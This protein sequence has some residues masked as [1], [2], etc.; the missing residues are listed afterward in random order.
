[1]QHGVYSSTDRKTDQAVR[2]ALEPFF[3]PI[4][5]LAT[6][7]E[8]GYPW[9][10]VNRDDVPK[11]YNHIQ[12]HLL[13]WINSAESNFHGVKAPVND[14][15]VLERFADK[16]Y[17]SALANPGEITA[18]SGGG[19]F[20]VAVTE[21]MKELMGSLINEEKRKDPLGVL[22]PKREMTKR[23]S[24]MEQILDLELSP[25]DRMMMRSK[26]T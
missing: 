5:Q 21:K 26:Q 20:N 11:I 18:P 3:L 19:M 25:T 6:I 8:K 10:I 22:Q 14:L 16:I 13:F 12:N 23:V 7:Y 24:L 17:P 9:A 4:S 2:Y 15:V 1:M